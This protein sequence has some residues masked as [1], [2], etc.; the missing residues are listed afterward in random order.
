MTG[1]HG[2][3]PWSGFTALLRQHFGAAHANVVFRHPALKMNFISESYGPEFTGRADPHQLYA[4]A[5][6]PITY[7]RMEAFKAYAIEDFVSAH[8]GEAHPFLDDFLVPLGIGSVLICRVVTEGGLQAW[9]SVARERERPFE[10]DDRRVMERI[11]QMFAPAL[12]L[13]GQFKEIAN[14]RDAYA[15]VV[16]ARATGLVR[17]DH[18]G[19]VL[20]VDE[21][22]AAWSRPGG[23]LC[24]VNGRL[25]ATQPGQRQELAAAISRVI[26]GQSDEELVVLEAKDGEG[27]ELLMFPTS[28]PFE[29]LWPS[30]P[31]AIVYLRARDHDPPPRP[32]RLHRMFGLSRRE[33]MLASLLVRGMTV[34]EAAVDLGISEQTARSYL[35]QVFEK[36]GVTRQAE[37]VRIVQGSI[38]SVQ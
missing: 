24:V 9:I 30:T 15:R 12:V 17:L 14:Q 1:I 4:P 11:C 18:R 23:A 27:L 31:R 36:T 26:E 38:A 8:G 21:A 10:A 35:R 20:L 5:D 7:Y 19:Q 32:E 34:A 6:D 16:R 3:P 2:D 33:A 37:L 13:F 28:D 29:P 25:Q 22:A